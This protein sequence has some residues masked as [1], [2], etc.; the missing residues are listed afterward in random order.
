MVSRLTAAAN[1]K[2]P[3]VAAIARNPSHF[4]SY[5]K[6]STRS[7][8][9]ARASIGSGSALKGIYAEL[10][11]HPCGAGLCMRRRLGWCRSALSRP[12]APLQ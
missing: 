4:T 1:A 5:A 6:S 11:R 3:S 10:E 8:E 9:S 7:V 12:P 2:P